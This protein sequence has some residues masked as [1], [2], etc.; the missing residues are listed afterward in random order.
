MI[1]YQLILNIRVLKTGQELKESIRSGDRSAAISKYNYIRDLLSN[2]N[3]ARQLQEWA[4]ENL[5]Y[6]AHV[7]SI[8]GL[9]GVAMIKIL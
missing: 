3:G 5:K 2:K 6:Q 8:D 4:Q 7:V 1:E 9:Y